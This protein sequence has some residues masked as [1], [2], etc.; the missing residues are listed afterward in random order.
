M[1]EGFPASRF[2]ALLRRP[3]GRTYYDIVSG[4][5]SALSVHTSDN[6]ERPNYE[7]E[8]VNVCRDITAVYFE[9]I[10]KLRYRLSPQQNFN[11]KIWL[12]VVT[13]VADSSTATCECW[14][15][16]S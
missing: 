9:N 1:S 7:G 6:K 15:I 11:V 3:N 13:I 10:R 16:A 5:R 8:S 14:K 2:T 12:C 4:T